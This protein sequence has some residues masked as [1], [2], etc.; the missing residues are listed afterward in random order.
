VLAWSTPAAA[1]QQIELLF[2]EGHYSQTWKYRLVSLSTSR[3][4][5]DAAIVQLMPF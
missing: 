2:K 4:P 1:E 5:C 3:A